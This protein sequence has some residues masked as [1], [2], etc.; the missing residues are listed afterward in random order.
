MLSDTDVEK[1]G[2]D[3][4]EGEIGEGSEAAA[5]EGFGESLAGVKADPRDLI[6]P[7]TCFIG[8][9]P[10]GSGCTTTR[11]LLRARDLPL[12]WQRNHT[13]AQKK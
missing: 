11:R 9:Y 4:E 2:A 5:A 10:S 12:A 8:R 3:V 7:R 1:R 6:K 13:E